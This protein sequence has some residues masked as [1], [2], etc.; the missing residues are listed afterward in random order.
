MNRSNQFT[1]LKKIVAL[2][3]LYTICRL[4]F[5]LFNSVHFSG[6]FSE[7]LFPAFFYG[8]YFDA[9]TVILLNFLFIALFLLPFSFREK[10]VWQSLL[11]WIFVIINSLALLAN[12]ADLVY[13]QFTLKRTTADVF[14]FFNGGIGNDLFR[15]LPQFMA[16]YWYVFI[17][18]A[19]FTWLLL[20]IYRR[21]GEV[22]PIEWNRRQYIRQSLLLLLNLGLAVIMYRG[23]FQLRPIGI[24][25]A[26]EFVESKY[27]PLL[28]NSPFS[29]LKTIEVQGIEPKIYYT[30]EKEMKML[31][32]PHHKAESGGFKKLNVFV[33][34]LESFSKEYIGAINGRK[35][36]DTPFLD[37]L[38]G[39]SLVFTN[40]FANGKRS[41][42]GIP[43]IVAG[44]PSWSDEAFITSRYGNNEINSLASLLK[45]EGYS[46]SFFHGGTN[47]TMGFDAFAGLAGYDHYYGRTEYNNEKDYDGNWGIWDEEFLQ[48][49]A[50][51]TDRQPQPFFSTVFTL[52]SHHPYPIPP[53]Y[54]GKFKEGALEID[55]TIRYSDFAL[56]QFFETAK[57]M[58]WFKN[59]L[60][61]LAA[62]HTGISNDPFFAGRLGNFSIPI[63]YYL[64]GSDLKGTDSTFTQQIDILPS[65]LDYLDYPK[66]YFAYGNSVFDPVASHYAFTYNSGCYE[67]IE[68]YFISQYADNRETDL[69]YFKNDS[70]LKTDV[71]GL[72]QN[73]VIYMERKSRAIIQT[74]QQSIINNKMH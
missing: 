24:V 26:G 20:V 43:A 25:N 31:I 74:Y 54:K 4:L 46:T 27:V 70:T 29:I 6:S 1:L 2:L 19:A 33:I 5:Y 23:G 36:G 55:K 11:K 72:H 66:P 58:P 22:K 10:K 69:Y 64:P 59:T 50:K 73:M 67:L 48:Y 65:V 30:D 52:T 61:V 62:D 47:G 13:F 15:L 53:K 40:A 34:A 51:M 3:G 68:N 44:I 37:S 45:A 71:R 63:I 7:N 17:I 9:S 28:L 42:E 39:E 56:Q 16:D 32:N 8:V 49:T 18:W 21:T 60:F 35:T 38:I 57:K 12:C 41:I 14:N